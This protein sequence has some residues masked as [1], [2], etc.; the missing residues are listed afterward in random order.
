MSTKISGAVLGGGKSSRL[1]GRNKAFIEIARSRI[2]DRTIRLFRE[3]FD[4]TIIIA[5]DPVPYSSLDIPLFTDV[6]RDAG[7]L[8]GIHSA[9][10]HAKNDYVFVAPC[11]MPFLS[12]KLIRHM[13]SGIDE[14]VEVIVPRFDDEWEP[15]HAIYSRKCLPFIERQL[16]KGER[17]IVTFYPTVRTRVITA[18]ECESISLSPEIFFNINTE[19][20]MKK[21]E[22]FVE[23]H[24]IG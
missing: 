5:N 23:K 13:I 6:I 22:S 18:D 11:D 8:G 21:A 20:D 19:G 15:L 9:L 10:V 1:G 17:R 16:E 7:P 24:R 3:L 14:A 2:I 4:E 12:E